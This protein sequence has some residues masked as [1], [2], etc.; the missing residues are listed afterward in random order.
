MTIIVTQA[1]KRDVQNSTLTRIRNTEVEKVQSAPTSK[2]YKDLPNT[3]ADG[4]F[5][6]TNFTVEFEGEEPIQVLML[7]VIS[8]KLD[9]IE[10]CFAC[11][12]THFAIKDI[13]LVVRHVLMKVHI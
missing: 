10:N 3:L 9:L 7:L 6:I 12:I 13:R 11:A 2:P 8:L 4:F 5:G 1:V